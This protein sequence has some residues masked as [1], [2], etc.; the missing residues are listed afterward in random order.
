MISPSKIAPT[1]QISSDGS[2][3]QNSVKT[4]AQ[5]QENPQS[6]IKTW[7]TGQIIKGNVLQQLTNGSLLLKIGDAKLTAQVN[8]NA[9][10]ITRLP[11]GAEVQLKVVKT[12]SQP[13]LQLIDTT[14]INKETSM[15]ALRQVIPK[16]APLSVFFSNLNQLNSTDQRLPQVIH[17]AIQTLH[18]GLS[19][20]MDM[21]NPEGVKKALAESGSFLEANLNRLANSKLS[22]GIEGDLKARLLRLATQL[23]NENFQQKPNIDKNQLLSLLADSKALP[24]L[25]RHVESALARIQLNQLNS[26]PNQEQNNQAFLL[27]LPIKEN[28]KIDIF[29]LKVKDE[30]TQ[31]NG[32]ES[33]K[34][35]SIKL[36]FDLNGLGPIHAKLMLGGEQIQAS[37]WAEEESTFSLIQNNLDL[38]KDRL[39]DVK[40]IDPEIKCYKGKP[41]P[42]QDTQTNYNELIDIQI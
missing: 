25:Q 40:F 13:L 14:K 23:S 37:L 10:S 34:R 15:A 42:D 36:S 33:N 1:S 11:V 21:L 22:N 8:S 41:E 17:Q 18:A 29:S 26:L 24:D 39:V 32:A 3:A 12:T 27:E 20:R 7:V 2:A 38:L 9:S 6:S 16:Q 28:E 19:S 30:D 31:K 4:Q 5:A 35:W